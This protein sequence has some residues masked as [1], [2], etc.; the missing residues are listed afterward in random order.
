MNPLIWGVFRISI[1][2]YSF[3]YETGLLGW[4]HPDFL[5]KRWP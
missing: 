5:S 3:S 1:S 4:K 2:R